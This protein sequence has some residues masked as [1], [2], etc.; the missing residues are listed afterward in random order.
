[1][2]PYDVCVWNIIV[3]GK[4]FTIV[5]HINDLLLNNKN[6]NIVTLY[7]R[8][9]QQEYSSQEGITVIRGKIHEY[10]GVTLDFRVKLEVHFSQYEFLKKLFNSLPKSMKVGIK[11]TA[12]PEYLFKTTYNSCLL[13]HTE[14]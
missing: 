3:N 13:D 10:L 2:N 11:Y 6:P 4:Q 5:F 1:M 12:A 9:L 8:K 14:K 7:I